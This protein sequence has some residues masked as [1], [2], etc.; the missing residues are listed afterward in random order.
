SG[1]LQALYSGFVAGLA[2]RKD[3]SVDGFDVANGFLPWL[4]FPNDTWAE[5][6][7]SVDDLQGQAGTMRSVNGS[8]LLLQ[9]RVPK[10]GGTLPDPFAEHLGDALGNAKLN[11]L[12]VHN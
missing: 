2:S 8:G 4:A 11:E 10:Q 1:V 6:L 5:W 3:S 7:G 12:P 9:R